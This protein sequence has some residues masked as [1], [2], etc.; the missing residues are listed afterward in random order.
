MSLGRIC[1]S[2]TSRSAAGTRSRIGWPA[3]MLVPGVDI[4]MVVHP[5]ASRP[6]RSPPPGPPPP[7]P[8]PHALRRAQLLH[9]RG[10]RSLGRLQV[11]GDVGQPGEAQGR[12]L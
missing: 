4:W 8:R 11:V 3:A 6:A 2:T 5:P 12:E 10:D 7:P 1:P 9:R